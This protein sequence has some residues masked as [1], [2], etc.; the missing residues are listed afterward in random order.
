VNLDWEQ[1]VS[2]T[3]TG[4]IML[5]NEKGKYKDK[6]FADK[7]SGTRPCHSNKTSRSTFYLNEMRILAIPFTFFNSKRK[8]A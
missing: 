2:T 7:D 6:Q 3:G 8:I 5:F 4:L 1:T